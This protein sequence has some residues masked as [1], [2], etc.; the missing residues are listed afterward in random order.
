MTKREKLVQK[1]K[2]GLPIS[3]K[4]AEAFMLQLGFRFDHVVLIMFFTKM[5]MIKISR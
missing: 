5:D 3:Y 2:A 1:I 4:E